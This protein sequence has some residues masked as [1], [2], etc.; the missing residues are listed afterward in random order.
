[1]YLTTLTKVYNEQQIA[2]RPVVQMPGDI[3]HW[4]KQIQPQHWVANAACPKANVR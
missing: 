4:A 3:V 1:M 2:K